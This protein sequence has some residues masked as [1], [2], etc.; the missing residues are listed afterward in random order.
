[1]NRTKYLD[2]QFYTYIKHEADSTHNIY[3]W[4]NEWNNN[5]YRVFRSYRR[6]QRTISR[7]KNAAF[8]YIFEK[9]MKLFNR[10]ILQGFLAAL[11][12]VYCLCVCGLV[13]QWWIITNRQREKSVQQ[14]WQKC[15]KKKKREIEKKREQTNR[16][17]IK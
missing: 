14:K 8:L 12:Y 10:T 17:Y 11:Y 15:Q 16:K 3:E 9:K 2:T 1:M 4:K 5:K 7:W 6:I 13:S